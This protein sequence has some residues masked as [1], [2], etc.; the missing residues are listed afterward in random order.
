LDKEIIAK[1]CLRVRECTSWGTMG[2]IYRDHA[3]SLKQIGLKN[4]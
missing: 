1:E 4:K 2:K 3:K